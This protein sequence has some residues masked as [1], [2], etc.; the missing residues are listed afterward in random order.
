MG[1]RSLALMN[2]KTTEYNGRRI[3]IIK[4]YIFLLLCFRCYWSF[5]KNWKQWTSWSPRRIWKQRTSWYN[6]SDRIHWKFRTT[7]SGR[8]FIEQILIN[9]YILSFS[10][11]GNF[12]KSIIIEII[13]EFKTHFQR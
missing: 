7:W 10:F 3:Y 13:L 9:N 1:R 6:W 8:C 2:I 5:R 11:C 4:K 12:Y